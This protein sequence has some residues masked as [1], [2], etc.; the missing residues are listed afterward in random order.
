MSKKTTKIWRGNVRDA[1]L[2]IL[3]SVEKNQSYSNLLLHQTIETYDISDQDR[4]LL[5]E[6]T[7]GCIQRKLTLDYFL[8]PFV[9]GKLESWVRLLLHLSIYQLVYLDR[10]PNHAI[11]HESVEIAKKRGHKGVAAVVNGILRSILREGVRSIEE[12]DD[13]NLQLSIASSHPLWLV[14]RWVK[15]FGYEKTAEMVHTN[16]VPPVQTVRVNLMKTTPDVVIQAFQ[17]EGIE[18]EQSRFVPE[19]LYVMKG[20]IAKT[21]LFKHGFVTIQDESSMIPSLL[22]DVEK[23]NRILDMCAAP[24]G[25]TTHIAERLNATGSLTS[26]DLHAHKVKLIDEQVQRLELDN[27][28]TIV[29]NS[30]E[31]SDILEEESFDRILVDAPCSGLGVIRRKPDIKY[32]K[33]ASDFD[34]LHVTQLQLLDE[35][36]RLLRPEGRLVYSTCTIEATENNETVQAFLAKHPE[37]EL[38]KDVALPESLTRFYSDGMMQLFPQ[39]LNSDGFFIAVFRK[40]GVSQ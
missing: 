9:K 11:V 36:S 1:A 3:L 16:N 13:E 39:D 8:E 15:Q 19:C 28:H 22:L 33:Q 5:T 4:A 40:K 38:L 31:L 32:T 30:K 27:V 17:E 7:Y 29:A 37:M 25:K 35:A 20:S 14:E 12:I 18:V 6:L 10:I 21:D 34:S 23:D 24:G 2:S 26:V